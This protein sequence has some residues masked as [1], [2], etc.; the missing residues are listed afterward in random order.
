VIAKLRY[1]VCQR[2]LR[3]GWLAIAFLVAGTTLAKSEPV[4]QKVFLPTHS[5]VVLLSGLAGDLESENAYRDQIQTWLEIVAS[6]EPAH[7]FLLCENPEAFALPADVDK[8]PEATSRITLHA[9]RT[10]FL[11]LS[12]QVSK[13]NPLV[14]IAWGHGGR[15][16]S[17]PVFHVRGPRI[18][19]SD[20]KKVAEGISGDSRWILMFRGSGAFARE[21]AKTSRFVLS[22]ERDTM[23]SSDP[24]GVPLLLKIV[25]SNPEIGLERLTE[26]FGRATAAW[27]QERSLARTEEPTFWSN[28]DPRLL[29]TASNENSFA[30]TRTDEA[31][32][33]EHPAKPD[34]VTSNLPP[35]WEGIRHAEATHYPEADAVLL[36][37]RVKYTLASNPALA[38][39][40]EEFIQVLTVEGKRFGDF[41]ISYSP[42][43]EEVN[44]LDCEV[45]DNEGKL[46][47]LDPESVREGHDESV[48]EY[49]FGRRKVFSLPGIGPGAVLHVRYRTEWKE[50][51]LPRVSLEIPL[52]K[53]MPVID[54]VIEVTVP[55][56][57][58][59]HFAFDHLPTSHASQT[60]D[61]LIKQS[62]YGT[63][64]TWQLRDIPTLRHE[65]LE[66]PGLRPRLLVSTFAD[67]PAFSGWYARISQL[68]DD[69]TPEIEAKAKELTRDAKSE[70]EKV[71]ALYDYV[72]GLR[73]VA[74]P[75]GIN[76]FRPHAA[77]N[78]F[79]NQYGDCK[80]K[81]NLLNTMLKALEVQARLVLVPRFGQ[82][83]ESLPGLAFNHAISQVKLDGQE[84]W[85][86][87][88]DEVCRF[89][90]LPPGDAGRKVLVIDGKTSSL[91]TLPVPPA[92]EHELKIR[93]EVNC[94]TPADQ[95]PGTLNA[96][97]KGF[98]DYQ[99]RAAARDVKEHAASLPLLEAGFR[100]AAGS[101]ALEK[102][103]STP[104]S[105]LD[106]DFSWKANGSW[107]GLVSASGGQR[108]LR[109]P[110]FVPK[111]WNLALHHRKGSLFLNEGYPLSLDEEF[112][113]IMPAETQAW[114]LPRRRESGNGVLKWAIEWTNTA[115]KF[116]ARLTAELKHGELSLEET[117][118]FQKQ[119]AA[120]LNAAASGTSWES[121]Q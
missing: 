74:V 13:T 47:R 28:G 31:G 33:D 3:K 37:R 60:S 1:L 44:F 87:T 25:R 62:T 40:Q 107:I 116:V 80:D 55:K 118:E 27:Y 63:T 67:W 88:T 99:L 103:T 102:Q 23:F 21:L 78:V 54:S 17:T 5:T 94:Q 4:D 71:L 42:P 73:Y 97:A 41:D 85:L 68:A 2:L 38:S 18:T 105:E 66:P 35:T 39:E 117:T 57:S 10:N 19:P 16:G 29:I 119:L 11:D 22:S 114:I 92:N 36:K 15:Q 100:A 98:P 7:V 58:P 52:A 106:E 53:D 121:R 26:D 120:L 69:I 12:Q 59:F 46:T 110:F 89:G 45:L 48:G 84:L 81:A 8:T 75:L 79:K 20:F 51:P 112:S 95:L 32:H 101:F 90:M 43:F 104:V 115:G 50:F 113:L 91:T 86:D 83:H 6:R 61:P 49:Q 56:D 14:V 24:I 9:T 34:S 82:A 70:R 76:S 109:A 30:S 96:V 108:I 77:A 93:G 65:V 111:E 64:Y 72:A